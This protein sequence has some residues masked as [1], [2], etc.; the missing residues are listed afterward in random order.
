MNI[1]LIPLRFVTMLLLYG[2]IC[3]ET[4]ACTND[5]TASSGDEGF[6]ITD[7]AELKSFY[8]SYAYS[9]IELPGSGYEAGDLVQFI[10]TGI[11]H[12]T[13]TME[14]ERNADGLTVSLPDNLVSGEYGIYI[15]RQG[16]KFHYGTSYFGRLDY[17]NL[18]A[19][20]HPRL[21]I[22]AEGFETLKAKLATAAPN[23]ILAKIHEECIFV[24]D[25]W[26]M[27]ADE[28][29]FQLDASNKRILTVSRNAIM[30]IFSCAYAYRTTGDRRYLEHA[31]HDINTVCNFESWNAKS[32]FL[33]PTEMA[34]AV[35]M[36]YDWL[37][38]ELQPETR[39]NVERALQEYAFYP[40]EN[41][42]WNKNFYESNSNWNQVCCCGLTCGALAIFET[43]PARAAAHIE[44]CIDSNLSILQTMYAP[45]GCYPEGYGYWGYGTSFECLMMALLESTVGTENGLFD[46]PGFSRTGD[47][48]LHMIGVTGSFNYSD[49]GSYVYTQLPL[50]YFADKLGD[51]SMLYYEYRILGMENQH[52]GSN[53]GEKR[54]LPMIM[55]FAS[56][57]NVDA[58]PAPQARVWSGNGATPVVLVRTGWTWG[59]SDKFLGM[60]GGMA[61]TSHGHMDAGS[62]VYDAYNVRWATDLGSEDYVT[63]EVNIGNGPTWDQSQESLRWDVFK[64]NNRQHN[65]LT[66]NGA[67]HLV[68]GAATVTEVID[69][70]T[71]SG[72]TLD[73][74]PVFATEAARVVRTGKIV[75][76]D[77]LEIIDQVTALDNKEAEIRWSLVTEAAATVEESRIVLERAGKAVTIR[78]ESD[79]EEEI[80]YTSFP[81]RPTTDYET[82][83]DIR[84]VGFEST[85]PAGETRTF[86]TTLKRLY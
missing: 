46:S 50:W 85:V 55:P 41:K 74:T 6:S 62:F 20:N 54:L 52:Y 27:A 47:Y 14:Y 5:E 45:D 43:C 81:D 66:I 4:S 77:Y 86:R 75:D 25:V 24:A 48:I 36:G 18:T 31:E 57:L 73:L 8:D 80:V 63:L 39:A 1:P 71:E 11:S 15:V 64:L 37:Y 68:K 65:T 7:I 42:I 44:K 35:G 83:S 67:K 28:L 19:E 23:S 32:H 84:I 76:D 3:L 59:E 40:A 26:G 78:T 69:T 82:Q 13:Y 21:L 72:G 22:D 29:E 70:E 2:L 30:R 49:N 34:V 17:R 10:D 51:P 9:Q 61:S 38:D 60:K 53:C 58:P 79:G 33:D 16:M 56:R 12:N